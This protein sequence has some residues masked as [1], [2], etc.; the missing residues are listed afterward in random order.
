LA[1]DECGNALAC[2]QEAQRLV[3]KAK[4]AAGGSGWGSSTVDQELAHSVDYYQSAIE[5]ALE[6]ANKENASLYFQRIPSSPPQ[7]QAAS[8]VNPIPPEGLSPASDID[9]WFAKL[10]SLS[11]AMGAFQQ[12]SNTPLPNIDDGF[13]RQDSGRASSSSSRSGKTGAGLAAGLGRFALGTAAKLAERAFDELSKPGKIDPDSSGTGGTGGTYTSSLGTN[14]YRSLR[15]E[16]YE[17]LADGII[18]ESLQAMQQ[19]ED[20]KRDVLKRWRLPESLN[21]LKGDRSKAVTPYVMQ[22]Q[23]QQLQGGVK[24][25]GQ[26]FRQL[27]ELRMGT[28]QE[29]D[30]AEEELDQQQRQMGRSTRAGYDAAVA[31]FRDALAGYRGNLRD[32]MRQDEKVDRKIEQNQQNFEALDFNVAAAQGGRGSSAASAF[33]STIRGALDSL[34]QLSA[35]RSNLEKAFK[36]EW[37]NDDV[38]KNRAQAPAYD[39]EAP[40]R[41]GV[42]RYEE[43][44][45]AV[46]ENLRKQDEVLRGINANMRIFGDLLQQSTSANQA[47]EQQFQQVL[48]DYNETRDNLA[49]GLGFYTQ[50]QDAVKKLHQE[51]GDYCLARYLESTNDGRGSRSDHPGR[52][53]F[54]RGARWSALPLQTCMGRLGGPPPLHMGYRR[55]LGHLP[56]AATRMHHARH[57]MCPRVNASSRCALMA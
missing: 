14:R 12:A 37:E 31:E 27:Q 17:R 47:A 13:G 22:E 21:Y 55:Q 18:R 26:L 38:L 8:L 57:N 23:K 29:L 49:E 50:L 39:P 16:D 33:V 2:L 41:E 36:W 44:R 4:D 34:D 24:Y 40:Y 25:L 19:A 15:E 48:R 30:R 52:W 51:V 35:E 7:L 10:D 32:A 5:R 42:R 53:L 6:K 11:P 45:R 54:G 3:A 1:A 46:Q 20:S 56:S 43:V 28:Q 9:Q